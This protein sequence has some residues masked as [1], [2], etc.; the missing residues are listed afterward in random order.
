[1]CKEQVLVPI[2]EFLMDDPLCV[3]WKT[4]YESPESGEFGIDEVGRRCF[5]LD[6]CIAPAVQALWN[7]RVKTTGCCCGHG[8]GSGVIGILTEYEHSDLSEVHPRPYRPLDDQDIKRFQLAR[9]ERDV[10]TAVRIAVCLERGRVGHILETVEREHGH[11]ETIVAG[12]RV[13]GKEL[14]SGRLFDQIDDFE[15]EPDE[16]QGS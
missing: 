3:H 8:S 9:E 14:W 6:A 5:R 1:M 7:A 13:V 16:Q 15:G 11:Y 10:D 4:R 12:L 2:P